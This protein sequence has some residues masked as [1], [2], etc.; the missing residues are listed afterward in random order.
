LKDDADERWSELPEVIRKSGQ[1]SD[2]K[3]GEA[4]L[5]TRNKESDSAKPVD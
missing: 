2:Y 3:I 4:L 1:A 5:K